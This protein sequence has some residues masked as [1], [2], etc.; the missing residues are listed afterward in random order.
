MRKIIHIDCDCFFAAVEMRDF[1]SLRYQPLAIGGRTYRR[2]VLST[3]NYEARQYGL[4][5]AMPTSTALRLCPQLIL[6]PAR[7]DAYKIASR[8][9]HH[10][11]RRYSDQI[12][13]ISLDEAF[14]DVS[15]SKICQGSASLIAQHIRQDI[16]NEIGITASAGIAPNKFL[17]KIASDWNKP[18]NQF[19][20]TPDSIDTF[21]KTLSVAK[22]PGVG[23]KSL[24]KMKALGI[25]NC[26]DLQVFDEALLHQHFGVFASRLKMFSLGIDDRPVSSHRLRKS[27]SIEQTFDYDVNSFSSASSKIAELYP[28]FEKRLNDFLAAQPIEKKPLIKSLH[29]KLKFFD[30][31]HTSISCQNSAIA[32]FLFEQLLSE[33]WQRTEKPVRLIGIGVGFFYSDSYTLLSSS[34]TMQKQLSLFDI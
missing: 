16:E 32:F 26:S 17:A 8:Q 28:K 14:L 33:A 23:K 24:V 15:D 29:L 1:P 9:M 20:I 3:C 22:L 21:I 25:E 2:G 12:E 4:H 31:S 6:R 10:I 7:H 5:S 27:L 18:N 34:S 13:P 30:F 19:V 11:F